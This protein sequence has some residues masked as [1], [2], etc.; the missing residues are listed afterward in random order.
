MNIIDYELT[1]TDEHQK[2]YILIYRGNE[3]IIIQNAQ[4][5]TLIP[6]DILEKFIGIIR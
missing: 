3:N 4:G 5:R 2:E 1:L 6:R